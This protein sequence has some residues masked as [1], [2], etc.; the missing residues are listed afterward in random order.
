MLPNPDP[1]DQS[2]NQ[3]DPI[4]ILARQNQ[5]KWDHSGPLNGRDSIHNPQIRC[6]MHKQFQ[7]RLRLLQRSRAFAFASHLHMNRPTSTPTPPIQNTHPHRTDDHH[8]RHRRSRP[9]AAPLPVP[10]APPPRPPGRQDGGAAAGAGRAAAPR[11]RAQGQLRDGGA[12]RQDGVPV[13][14]PAHH[15]GREAHDGQGE[16]GVWCGRSV[17][18]ILHHSDGCAPSFLHN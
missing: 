14:P 9:P 2:N 17:G 5:S 8:V 16:C 3:I 18:A 1:F 12:Q 13:R 4:T 6:P 15:S 7:Q 11:G 10:R